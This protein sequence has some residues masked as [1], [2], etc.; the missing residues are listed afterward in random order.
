MNAYSY[1]ISPDIFRLF[2]GYVRGVVIAHDVRNGPSP[3]ELVQ[4]LRQA[5]ESVRA[6]L[7][8]E[9]VAEEPRIAAW[10]EAYRKF[11]AKPSEFRS[12]VEAMARRALRNEPLPVINTLVDIGNVLSLRRLIPVGGHAIDLLNGD[13]ALRLA[14]GGEEFVPF[15]TTEVEHPL[16]GEVIF[17]EGNTVLTRRWTWRQGNHTLTLPETTAIEFNVDGLPPLPVSEV[18]QACTEV[19]DLVRKFCGGRVRAEML[20]EKN[21]RVSLADG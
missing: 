19:M 10:R 12:S 3:E 8:I 6:R 21:Q 1:S 17:A 18:E 9:K 11:G 2:P 20:S 4:M 15:G 7:T 5:E 13:I 14:T 16:P